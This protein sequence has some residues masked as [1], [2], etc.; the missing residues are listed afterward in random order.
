[1]KAFRTL[2]EANVAG[3]RVLVRIDLNVPMENGRV[4]DDTRIRAAVPTIC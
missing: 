1:M 3:K 2:D 4:Y